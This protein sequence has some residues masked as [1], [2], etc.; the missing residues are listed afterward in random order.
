MG[1]LS[2]AEESNLKSRKRLRGIA[3]AIQQDM[4]K[5][6]SYISAS[7][8]NAPIAE[9]TESTNDNS[10]P[11]LSTQSFQ[12]SLSDEGEEVNSSDEERSKM[13]ICQPNG[14]TRPVSLPYGFE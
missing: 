10:E 14:R 2:E 5:N 4:R 13:R 9:Y 11:V 6:Q 1:E 8:L 12:G 7:L 3:L